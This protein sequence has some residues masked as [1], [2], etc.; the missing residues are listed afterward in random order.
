MSTGSPNYAIFNFTSGQL[1][2][3]LLG[4]VDLASYYSGGELIQNFIP[5]PQGGLIHRPGTRF[6]EAPKTPNEESVLIRFVYSTE[7]AYILEFGNA[8]FRIYKDGARVES[9]GTPVEVTTPYGEADLLNI[10][11]TQSADTLYLFCDGYQPRKITRTS[12]TSWTLSAVDFQDGPFLDEN[13]TATT[14]TPSNTTGNITLTAS[15]AIFAST[16]VGRLVRIKHSSKWGCAKITSYSSSTLVNATVQTNHPLFGTTGVT[17]WRLGA[18]SNNLGWPSVGEFHEGRLIMGNSASFPQTFWGSITDGF[19]QLSPTLRE[20]GGND[21]ITN[22]SGFSSTLATDKVNAIRWMSSGAVLSIGTSDGEFSIGGQSLNEPLTP[23]NIKAKRETNYGSKKI[24]PVKIDART[25]F[26]HR[27]GKQI[28][29]YKYSFEAD[30]YIAENLN[31]LSD[32]ILNS[33]VR[34][35]TFASYKY[36]LL[37]CCQEDGKLRAITYLP[38]QKV[39]AWSEHAL[40]GSA[41]KVKSVAV[42]PSTNEDFDQLWMI[43]ER[44]INGSTTKH[45]EILENYFE[46]P[47]DKNKDDAF[48]VDTGLTLDNPQTISG[49]TKANPAVV[50]V[51]GHTFSNGDT[52]RILDV[53]GMTEVN[54]RNFLVANKTAN[55]FE[56]T[57]TEGNNIDSST[58]TAYA[59]GGEAHLAT[60]AISG[61]NHLEGEEVTIWADGATHPLKTVNS[62]AITLDRKAAIVHVGLGRIAKFKGF[63]VDVAEGNFT[64]QLKT[65][66]VA[67]IGLRLIDSAGEIKV[68]G[69][70]N[71]MESCYFRHGNDQMNESPALFTGIKTVAFPGNHEKELIFHL[72]LDQPSPVT[73][74]S[75][76]AEL[77]FDEL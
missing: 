72:Q 58:Y 57:D 3:K 1:S 12:H 36:P 20:S 13:L 11:Y 46:A 23:T 28:H 65:K 62:G 26:V 22:D 37:W 52:I 27:I 76:I 6:V 15:S 51:T 30:G 73:L 39:T 25:L 41:V 47:L 61:L 38:E 31:L 42:I 32:E 63:P 16:D 29:D 66:S 77:K 64:R 75:L 53:E 2:R 74:L 69:N 50:T 33:P 43:V 68:G 5:A 9:A 21:A 18:W 4:R 7:Q 70:F 14:I 55:T 34:Q 8:Y 17:T 45:I 40:G 67:D 71:Y 59:S 44:T 19:E 24:K 48:Y 49:I 60:T 10:Y 54:R 56:L 35:I